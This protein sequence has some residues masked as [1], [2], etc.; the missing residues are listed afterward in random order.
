[1]KYI[2]MSAGLTI[3]CLCFFVTSVSAAACPVQTDKAYKKGNSTAVWYVTKECK[4]RVFRKASRFMTYFSSWSSVNVIPTATLESIPKDT[5][6]FMPKGPKY[7]PKYG[8]VVKTLNDPK[9]YLLLGNEKYWIDSWE[10]Y[11]R[12]GYGRDWIEDVHKKLLDKYSTGVSVSLDSPYGKAVQPH[13]SLVKKKND[14]KVYRIEADPRDP[15]IKILRHIKSIAVFRA[16]GF[17][18][19]R[20]I[21]VD[22][23]A[24][25]ENATRN[26][27]NTLQ[28]GT[29]IRRVSDI[30]TIGVQNR[31]RALT[32]GDAERS[33]YYTYNEPIYGLTFEYKKDHDVWYRQGGVSALG[34]QLSITTD[35]THL[36]NSEQAL[37][38]EP[39]IMLVG[40]VNYDEAANRGAADDISGK[41]KN[42]EDFTKTYAELFPT[43]TFTVT[44]ELC[45]D[46][47]FSE[48]GKITAVDET[49]GETT[50]VYIVKGAENLYTFTSMYKTENSDAAEAAFDDFL[51]HT[52]LSL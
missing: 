14:S 46:D 30:R 29:P 21:V 11:L 6:R 49:K 45:G 42:T 25:G 35:H 33:D 2:A 32:Q 22:T 34:N 10:G 48:Y 31:I 16:L 43:D 19:D 9:V 12:L 51:A 38:N 18:D 44:K 52:T 7:D 28:E 20:I 47:R 8:A 4:R 5:K 41:S 39:Y 37:N 40:M 27:F 50:V 15:R 3:V 26:P 1:M 17:R 13:Y 24:T 36:A 23:N